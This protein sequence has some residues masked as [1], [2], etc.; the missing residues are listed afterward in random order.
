[1]MSVIS[2]I[3]LLTNLRRTAPAISAIVF[4][5]GIV[6]GSPAIA[7][8]DAPPPSPGD[9]IRFGYVIHQSA[10]FGGHIVTQS[11][12]DA[13]YD[14][15]VNIQSGPR[16]IDSSYQMVAVDRAHAILFDHLSS[17][18]FGYGG[19]PNDATF[20][21]ASKGRIYNFQGSFR[22]DRQYFDYN[23][24]AN[25]LIPPESTP[26]I[27][28][29]N[30]PHLYNTVRRMT[31]INFT[32]AP[33]SSISPRL[34]YFQN[35]NQGPSGSTVHVGGEGLLIQN[36]RISTYVW[37]AGVDWKPLKRTSVSFDEFIT[38]YKGNTTWDLTGTDY[39][40]SNGEPVSLG[41]DISSVWS[42]PCAKPF[43]PDGTVNP[44][45]S[46][47]L[48]YTRYGPTRT[49]LPS[50]QLRFQS[51]SIRNV[52]MNGRVMYMGTTSNLNN[53][54]ENFNGLNSR[55]KDRVELET[56]SAS[57]RRINVNADYGITWQI[58]PTI[59]LSDTF[60]F[61]YFRQPANNVFTQTNYAG[62][63]MLN[64]PGAATTTTTPDYQA[65][66]Q[67]TKVNTFLST[68]DLTPRV[69]LSVGYRYRSRIITDA[70]GDFVPIHEDAALFGLVLRP[71]TQLRVNFNADVM[72]ADNAFTRIS[73]RKRQHYQMRTT[74]NPRPWL[75]F[76]GT[77]NILQ[78]SD[79]VE[80]VEHF[81]H[82]HD[83]SFATSI[84]PSEKWGLDLH[85]AYD[86]V[87]SRT[88]ECY[89]SSAPVAGAQP[90]PSVC[91]EAGLPYQS[92]GLYNQ[93]TQSGTIGIVLTPIKKFHATAGYRVSAVN[94]DA[95]PI[96]IR[97]VPGSL[98]SQYHTPY[99][100]L[101]YDFTPNW[102]WKGDYNY[103]SY[104]EG[105]TPIGPTLPR[106]FHTN[107]V[108]LSIRYAF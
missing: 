84:N 72:S 75:N 86:S 101:A 17:S 24:L 42:A 33:L 43:N 99:G 96:N 64:P 22:R 40:L 30:S 1:M 73:P 27:P 25:P 85:Y 47:F 48:S 88:D 103:Y 74:Y 46:G 12:S 37:N 59:G 52:T 81:A 10:D 11:G 35:I 6:A 5:A 61:W 2:S 70:G 94:G 9:N 76:A 77:I 68:W 60:N 50:E 18:S 87:Y 7:Q 102:T 53:F 15:L 26:F 32:L 82:F 41:I 98:Q 38:Q 34:G 80:T 108:T 13:M 104:G 106:D 31:D 83:F 65:L 54:Y 71:V 19:D 92:N 3:S 51:A 57:A 58:T 49:L 100:N 14:T 20:M 16:L 29:L 62:T 90:S 21:T 39:N 95:P 69:R 23:L 45:C 78:S 56:G 107:N 79:N 97:Q 4:A 67:K 55:A 93:P 91:M 8:D 28:I 44:N 36:V 66:N 63:S 105:D 89:I